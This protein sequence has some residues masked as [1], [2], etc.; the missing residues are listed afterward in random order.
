MAS[1]SRDRRAIAQIQCPQCGAWAGSFCF[2]RGKPTKSL[3]G[4]GGRLFIHPERRR[5]NQDRLRA[6]SSASG[7]D[8]EK[9]HG[10]T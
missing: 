2:Y 4:T 1:D 3:P 6:A 8:W 5:A 9:A 7:P 10:R